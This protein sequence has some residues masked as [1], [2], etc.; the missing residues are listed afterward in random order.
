MLDIDKNKTKHNNT[1]ITTAIIKIGLHNPPTKLKPLTTLI[2]LA[3]PDTK[4]PVAIKKL[5]PN[6]TAIYLN[7][8]A[9]LLKSPFLKMNPAMSKITPMTMQMLA[10][11]E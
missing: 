10:D 1:V 2:L 6:A 11:N 3:R 9:V 5:K 4:N 8:S 7:T